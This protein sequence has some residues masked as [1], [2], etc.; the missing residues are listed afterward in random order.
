MAITNDSGIAFGLAASKEA[1]AV[2]SGTTVVLGVAGGRGEST[3]CLDVDPFNV[4]EE[5]ELVAVRVEGGLWLR[6]RG[7]ALS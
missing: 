6:F 3:D 4:S 5:A 7:L 2:G 1:T